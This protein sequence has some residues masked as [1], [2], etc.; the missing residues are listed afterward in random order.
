MNKYKKYS[1]FDA[2][3]WVV[4]LKLTR[5]MNL[6]CFLSVIMCDNVTPVRYI[7]CVQF[8]EHSKKKTYESRIKCVTFSLKL[9]RYFLCFTFTSKYINFKC[10]LT[11]QATV[12]GR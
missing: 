6:F 5:F 11:L 7:F 1:I 10:K 4:W 12:Y 9:W 3:T 2:Y 8:L